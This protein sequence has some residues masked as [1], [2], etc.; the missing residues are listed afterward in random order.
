MP[1]GLGFIRT[2][3]AISA[4][5]RQGGGG[6]LNTDDMD[7]DGLLEMF[8]DGSENRG[9]A[10]ST[11]ENLPTTMIKDVE[12]EIPNE[13]RNCAICLEEFSNGDKRKTLECLHGFHAQ[14]VDRWLQSNASC[15]ICKFH[16]GR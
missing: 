12:K 14:C 10:A 13:H 4:Q 9:A 1:E 8:G 7:Y 16:V 11:I 6:L 15:P 5:N 3:A 2:V